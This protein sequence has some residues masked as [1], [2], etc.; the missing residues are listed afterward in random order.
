MQVIFR[1]WEKIGLMDME[2]TEMAVR[3]GMHSAGAAILTVLLGEEPP[4]TRTIDCHC[5]GTAAYLE[6]RP[7][8]VLTAVGW[9]QMLRAYYLCPKCHTGQ[10]PMDKELDV[11][12]T[13]FSPGVRRMMS[14]AGT[15]SSF[16]LAR[17]EME[18]LAGLTVT[19][20]A[21]ERIGESIG[22]DIAQ[23]QW[24]QMREIMDAKQAVLVEDG[25]TIPVMYI[26][27]D[28]TGIPIVPW[29]LDQT[30]PGKQG[31]RPR[32]REAK[33]GCVFTQTG[34]DS[35]G[36]PIRDPF[37][38]TYTGAIETAEE[39]GPRIYAE[40]RRRGLDRAKLVV[41]I[42]DA[43]SWIWAIARTH[44][45]GAIEILDLY[46]AREH[47]WNLAARLFPSDEVGRRRWVKRLQ[48]K[49]DNGKITGLVTELRSI[50][51]DNIALRKAIQTEADYYEKNADRMRYPD[52]KRQNLFVGSGVIEAGCKTV[53]GSRLK[54]SG[55]FWTIRGA[56]A[57]LALR[58][59]ILNRDFDDYWENRRA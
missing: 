1:G 18:A 50:R 48:N 25:E 54:R 45:P 44:F 38:T 16:D 35:E 47:L 12:K 57:I 17:Q 58:C 19:A 42:G 10:A 9:A 6:L 31:D 11:E 53:I 37:S 52:F 23:W 8:S 49:L 33:L 27:I 4:A 26:E 46:H 13:E 5:G 2:A 15:H 43:A 34:V 24:R 30:K 39:F 21:V 55:M 36:R 7:K 56:N 14:L 3:E 29:E 40:A 28:G 41:V 51:T 59:S 22:A 32:T 20:K